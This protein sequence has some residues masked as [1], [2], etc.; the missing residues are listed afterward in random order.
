M[1]FWV[2]P[3]G[4]ENQSLGTPLQAV[5]ECVRQH[6][7]QVGCFFAVTLDLFV[8]L[9]AVGLIR[10]ESLYFVPTV[11]GLA[12]SRWFAVYRIR[13]RIHPC[14]VSTTSANSFFPFSESMSLYIQQL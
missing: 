3:K 2:G 12:L 10:E 7:E 9:F 4:Q 8:L 6:P 14:G 11:L 5:Q 13:R 1:E